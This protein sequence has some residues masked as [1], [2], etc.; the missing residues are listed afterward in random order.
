MIPF[1][2]PFISGEELQYVQQAISNKDL[3]GDGYFTKKCQKHL[4]TFTNSKKVLLTGSCTQALEMCA[5]LTD[6]QPGDEVIMPSFTFVSSA[7][8]FVL[9]GAKIVFVDIRPDTMNINEQL[10]KHAITKKTKGILVM[11]YAGVACEMDA[12]MNIAAKHELIVIE[13]AAQCIGAYYKNKHLGTIGHLGTFSF[14]STKNIHCGEGGALLINDQRFAE[15]AE[16]LRDKGTNRNAFLKGIVNKYS[17]VD[18]GSSYSM[19]ELSAAFL[20]AQLLKVEEITQKRKQLFDSYAKELKMLVKAGIIK[21]PKIP[22][23]CLH[24]GHIFYIKCKDSVERAALIEQLKNDGIS[25]AFH[26]VPLHSAKAGRKFG[27]FAGEDN[28]TTKESEKLLR[29]PLYF[30][31]DKIEKISKALNK[32]YTPVWK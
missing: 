32:F 22:A 17:W 6:I 9:R 12:I 15:R 4:E 10:I 20:Y 14:H 24:N 7:N 3:T 1:N 31:L 16:I 18:I 5:L 23:E 28:F 25:T 29:L 13:D 21:L 2:I 11:H 27:I 30:D 8:A 26:Y 19:S